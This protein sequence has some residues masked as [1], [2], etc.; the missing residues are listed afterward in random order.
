MFIGYLIF[1]PETPVQICCSLFNWLVFLFLTD[2]YSSLYILDTSPLLDMCIANTVS[3]SVACL[4][5]SKV[6]EHEL[7]FLILIKSNFSVFSFMVVLLYF[8]LEV[9]WF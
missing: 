9:F 4:S 7:K 8:I 3:H 2:L 1:F 5:L 6:S